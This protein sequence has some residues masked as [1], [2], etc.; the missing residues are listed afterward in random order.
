MVLQPSCLILNVLQRGHSSRSDV[1][2]GLE[3]RMCEMVHTRPLLACS[4]LKYE[5]GSLSG[6]VGCSSPKSLLGVLISLLA[7]VC[8]SMGAIIKREGGGP[9]I[10]WESGCIDILVVATATLTI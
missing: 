1:Q 10:R 5:L 3:F 6:R 7:L 2:I 9:W 4:L 8:T